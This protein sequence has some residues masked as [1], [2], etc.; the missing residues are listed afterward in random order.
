MVGESWRMGSPEEPAVSSWVGQGQGR[1]DP[2][3]SFRSV[4]TP[5][6]GGPTKRC[7]LQEVTGL[8]GLFARHHGF[9]AHGTVGCAWA[10]VSRLS[11][12]AGVVTRGG[13]RREC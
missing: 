2:L 11:R 1:C 8:E 10:K 4:Q 5:G 7:W 6:E 13:G 3:G 9:M 12:D